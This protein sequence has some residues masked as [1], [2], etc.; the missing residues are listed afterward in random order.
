MRWPTGSPGASAVPFPWSTPTGAVSASCPAG[1]LLAQS[2]DRE[3]PVGDLASTDVVGVSPSASLLDALQTM[4]DENINHLPVLEDGRLVGICTRA[5]IVRARSDE[6]AL[7]RLEGGWLAPVLQ[8]RGTGE[9]RYLVVGYQ[10]LGSN[11]LQHQIQ[12]MTDGASAATTSFHVVV[13]LPRGDDLA[14]ARDRLEH[15]LHLIETAGAS[16]S[17]EIGADDPV[18]AIEQALGREGADRII[19]STLPPRRSRWLHG[20]LRTRI[21]RLIDVDVV[22]VHD[23]DN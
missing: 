6:L 23:D 2:F 21:R 1:D 15:Q 14:Q 3:G 17:G 7:E 12:A 8:R 10:S 5:D 16:A 20:D 9:R 18:V 22:V 11:A 19:L 13:P 4:V